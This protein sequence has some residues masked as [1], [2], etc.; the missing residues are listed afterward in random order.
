MFTKPYII[1]IYIYILDRT[2]E[3]IHNSF[4]SPTDLINTSI[5]FLNKESNNKQTKNKTK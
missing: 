4:C 2:T 1:F 5:I 3:L